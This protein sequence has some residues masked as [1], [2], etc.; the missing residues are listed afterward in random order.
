M[1]EGATVRLCWNQ[2]YLYVAFDFEDSDLVARS[3]EGEKHHY[4][5]SDTAELFLKPIEA[6]CYWEMHATP[7][8]YRATYFYPSSDSIGLPGTFDEHSGLRVAAA[9]G[10]TIDNESD[11]DRSWS[12]EFAIP[13]SDLARRTD[14]PWGAGTAWTILAGRYNYGRYNAACELTSRPTLPATD[15]HQHAHYAVL[16]LELPGAGRDE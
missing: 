8:G 9:A 11:R 12:V 5:F 10:G 7:R 16:A 1:F 6:P 2:A 4:R 13:V 14:V 3:P 15:F